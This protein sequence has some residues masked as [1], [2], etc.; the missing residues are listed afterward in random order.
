[1]MFMYDCVKEV[2]LHNKE[3]LHKAK[4]SKKQIIKSSEG[5]TVEGDSLHHS[6]LHSFLQRHNGL[7]NRSFESSTLHSLMDSQSL[8]GSSK[9]SG[10]AD[11]LTV[12]T[13]TNSSSTIRFEELCLILLR[14]EM[15]RLALQV[16]PC[17]NRYTVSKMKRNEL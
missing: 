10:V 2:H 6:L 9:N 16:N 8:L 11:H 15:E 1:M 13:S 4:L 17:Q 14:G 7:I 5:D 12:I 3:M